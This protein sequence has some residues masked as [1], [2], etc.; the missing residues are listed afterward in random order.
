MTACGDVQLDEIAGFFRCASCD[1]KA[2]L[3]ANWLALRGG[4]PK[5]IRIRRLVGVWFV[6][7][8]DWEDG[9]L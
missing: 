9:T 2:F 4:D 5:L 6:C 3:S 7:V 8:F 1:Q